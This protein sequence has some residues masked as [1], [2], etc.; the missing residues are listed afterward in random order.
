M[1]LDSIILAIKNVYTDIL[2]LLNNGLNNTKLIDIFNYFSNRI[3][4]F[5]VLIFTARILI[6]VFR[7]L[8]KVVIKLKA[9][10][11]NKRNFNKYKE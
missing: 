6:S 7:I 2:Y 1:I 3:T 9:F 11:I 8:G 5:I 10:Y 4:S